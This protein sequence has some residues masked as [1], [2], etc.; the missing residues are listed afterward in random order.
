MSSPTELVWF[1]RE[2]YRIPPGLGHV[3]GH[4]AKAGSTSPPAGA[5]CKEVGTDTKTPWGSNDRDVSD[6]SLPWL[7]PLVALTGSPFVSSERSDCWLSSS[8]FAWRCSLWQAAKAVR[9][10][11]ERRPL[12][13]APRPVQFCN[14]LWHT[15]HTR[16]DCSFHWWPCVTNKFE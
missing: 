13:H 9:A 11:E 4:K 7:I 14:R 5:A 6:T 1:Q 12:R 3:A 2:Q 15:S 8:L 16:L 10:V